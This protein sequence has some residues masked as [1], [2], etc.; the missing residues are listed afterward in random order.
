M[1]NIFFAILFYISM[2]CQAQ[3]IYSLRPS[4]I[5]LPE[6]SYQKD[7]NNE[8]P[9]YE[10]T[11][12]GTWDGKTIFVTFK[13]ITNAYDNVFKYYKDYLIGKFKILNAS[14]GVMY[15]N[16]NLSDDKT[17]INGVNFRKYNT[18]YSLVY[19]DSDL[20]NTSGNIIINF[21]DSSKTKLNWKFNKG[22]NMITTDCQYY[23][24]TPFPKALPE[25]IVL[26]KQ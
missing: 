11:W 2:S 18:K 22:S 4:E 20:C 17:K 8:L 5:Q 26:T 19:I 14:G 24:T 13:K 25:E 12:K 10:G 23:N 21:T 7:T 16:M 1:K 9:A 6:N 15:D 3:Q